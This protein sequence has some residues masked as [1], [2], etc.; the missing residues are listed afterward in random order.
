MTCYF[1]NNDQALTCFAIG[2]FVYGVSI[3]SSFALILDKIVEIQNRCTKLKI[4]VSS[5]KLFLTMKPLVW[6]W[7]CWTFELWRRPIWHT[8]L[9]DLQNGRKVIK[10]SRCLV[11]SDSFTVRYTCICL[12]TLSFNYKRFEQSI[13]FNILLLIKAT[14][15]NHQHHIKLQNTI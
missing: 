7:L 12:N 9:L 6:L 10:K 13:K 14:G 3:F 1:F 5:Y 4:D 15:P 8:Q 2:S 11:M